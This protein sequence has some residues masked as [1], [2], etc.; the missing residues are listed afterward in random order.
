MRWYLSIRRYYNNMEDVED[1]LAKISSR[2]A[3]CNLK[4]VVPEVVAGTFIGNEFY[5]YIGIESAG[6]KFLPP[7]VEGK[8]LTLSCLMNQG[9]IVKGIPCKKEEV[10]KVLGD[11][12]KRTEGKVTYRPLPILTREDVLEDRGDTAFMEPDEDAIITESDRYDHLRKYLSAMGSGSWD[13]F[14]AI[15]EA[16]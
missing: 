12:A 15:V 4:R 7:E 9:N 16:L 8:L 14:C 11:W 13:K 3:L 10:E 5:L 1:M 6:P 2:V